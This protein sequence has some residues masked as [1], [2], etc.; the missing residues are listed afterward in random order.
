MAVKFGYCTGSA[1]AQRF[2]DGGWD[3][4]EENIQGMLQGTLPE[5]QWTGAE[6]VKACPLPIIAGN[7]MVPATHKITG[8]AVDLDALKAYMVNTMLRA[9]QVGMKTLVFGS[10]GA[11]N[12]PDG[13]D[14]NKAKDQI[15][16]FLQMAA[17]LAEQAGVT[18][19]CEPLNKKESNI[20][21]SVAEG[22]EY[23][24]ALNHPNFQCLVD[25]Y[26]FWVEKEPLKNLEAA[27]PW[28]KHVHL[29][30]EHGRTAPGLSGQ[31]D[32]KPFFKVLKSA[33]YAG[34][35][36]VEATDNG[37][38]VGR[39]AEILKYVKDNWEAA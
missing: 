12:Y 32:Y 15:L 24:K 5:A 33:G 10:G 34:G 25:S 2:K 19:V 29:A 21:T 8:P 6:R 7:S 27:M 1:N 30:D 14:R 31:A 26:H 18:I 3:Y 37:K 9:K 22:M 39:E 35:V 36:S 4:V 23:V 13:F 17:Q 16:A 20:I 11:R 38:T 28:I